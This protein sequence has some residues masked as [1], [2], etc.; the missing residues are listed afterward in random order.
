MV[1]AEGIQSTLGCYLPWARHDLC[2]QV[3]ELKL[4]L[5]IAN[6]ACTLVTRHS[7]QPKLGGDTQT[8]TESQSRK[9]PNS[10][11]RSSVTKCLVF[12]IFLQQLI[13]F[14]FLFLIVS[15]LFIVPDIA[16]GI[17][18]PLYT[19][20]WAALLTTGRGQ[21]LKGSR[22]LVPCSDTAVKC[23]CAKTLRSSP[24]TVG[25]QT[26]EVTEWPFMGDDGSANWEGKK[27]QREELVEDAVQE[28]F[29]NYQVN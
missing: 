20:F 25:S 14:F 19:K 18:W 5:N 29:L 17:C 13:F 2:R 22:W 12:G 26:G 9:N 3:T 4:A 11:R 27:W 6:T 23:V 10:Q 8:S 21:R 1:K 24:W 7:T 16:S 28:I 15:F